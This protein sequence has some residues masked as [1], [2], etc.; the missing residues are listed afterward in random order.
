MPLHNMEG[1]DD[2]DDDHDDLDD[3]DDQEA[4]FTVSDV[5]IRISLGYC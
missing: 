1:S 2:D 5:T 3:D 4:A